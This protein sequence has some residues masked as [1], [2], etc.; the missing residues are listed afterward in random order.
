M[1]TL[2]LVCPVAIHSKKIY[3][4]A[5]VIIVKAMGDVKMC[6]SWQFRD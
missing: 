3:K 5:K 6:K 4:S 1:E 2:V